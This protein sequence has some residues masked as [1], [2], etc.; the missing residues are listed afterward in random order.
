MF[1]FWFCARV[2]TAGLMYYFSLKV[3]MQSMVNLV[4][5]YELWVGLPG[6][7][8]S[9]VGQILYECVEKNPL[10]P[11]VYQIIYK[12]DAIVVTVV[13]FCIRQT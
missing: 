1:R 12:T 8:F 4:P 11:Q 9:I 5:E 7:L 2:L 6:T 3:C 13:Y 10:M